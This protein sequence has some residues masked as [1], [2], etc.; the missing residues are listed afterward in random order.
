MLA[1]VLPAV[2]AWA[3]CQF[4]TPIYKSTVLVSVAA[5]E[6]SSTLNNISARFGRIAEMAGISLPSSGVDR[7]DSIATLRSSALAEEFI[8]AQD[9]RPSLFPSAWDAEGKA[10][11]KFGPDGPGMQRAVQR[12]FRDV[13]RVDEDPANGLLRIEVKWTDP[14][15]AARWANEYVALANRRL[16]ERALDI[17]SQRMMYLN[18]ELEKSGDLELRRAI[19]GLIQQEMSSAMIANIKK[20]FA[21]QVVDPAF[22]SDRDMPVWPKPVALIIVSAMAGFSVALGVIVLVEIWRT[23]SR[24]SPLAGRA[25]R[26]DQ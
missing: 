12:L 8:V 2:V 10:W 7:P 5:N 3:Y 14:G 1:T 26:A 21:F 25:S 24:A 15:L 4:A 22:P 11:R 20:D 19:Y 18:R 9:L 6:Q 23:G 13:L 17:A 16:Q